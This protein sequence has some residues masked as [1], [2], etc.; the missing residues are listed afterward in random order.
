MMQAMK[1]MK[2]QNPVMEHMMLTMLMLLV[3]KWIEQG[4]SLND[5]SN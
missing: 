1:E 3:N 2:H 5:I 4:N